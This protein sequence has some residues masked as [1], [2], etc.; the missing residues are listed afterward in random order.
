M[1]KDQDFVDLVMVHG[2]PPQIIWVTC[3]NML[4]AYLLQSSPTDIPNPIDAS[5]IW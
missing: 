1:S 3:G 2:V 4:N 5:E